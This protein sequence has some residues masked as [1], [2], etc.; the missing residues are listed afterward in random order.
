MLR[1]FASAF[2]GSIQAATKKI[3]RPQVLAVFDFVAILV[4]GAIA[5]KL[6][7]VAFNLFGVRYE[8][9]SRIVDER[10]SAFLLTSFVVVGWL[11]FKGS[12]HQRIP[13]WDASKNLVVACFF[14]LMVEGFVLYA[15]KSDVSRLLTFAT[16]IL[17]PLVVMALRSLERTFSHRRGVG[18]ANVVIVGRGDFAKNARRLLESD[19]H[20]GFRVVAIEEPYFA[21]DTN[22]FLQKYPEAAYVLVALSGSDD[23][24]NQVVAKLRAAE[25]DL[26]LVPVPNGLVAGM[27]VRYLLGEESILLIDR[28]EVVPFLNRLAKRAFDIFVSGLMLTA[29]AI[30]MTVVAW[31]VRR[32]GGPATYSHQRVGLNGNTF[33]CFKFRSMS[34]NADAMLE[35]YLEEAPER[36]VEWEQS[37]KLK[38]DPRVTRVGKL[39]RKTTLDELPQLFNVF[40]G[41]MSLVGPRPVTQG[42]L[43]YYGSTAALYK[44]VRPGLTGLW[45]VSGR[46]DLNYDQ[47]VRLDTWYVRNWTPWHDVAILLK[48]VPAVLFRRGAY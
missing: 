36:R 1:K 5:Y 25:V 26:I 8:S 2:T 7:E 20:L 9:W 45:Q 17:A 33:P 10:G 35:A 30:P 47:R 29:A 16:W 3:S 14:G 15:Y 27:E 42:E 13:F 44:S 23:D 34:V 46:S 39:I 12:Y 22:A 24:E 19:A 21:L 37:R 32:D 11:Y 41:Q 40:K 6:V 18:I 31:I 38:D 28:M 43:E 4:T 48:T